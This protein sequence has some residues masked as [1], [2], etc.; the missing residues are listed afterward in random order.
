MVEKAVSYVDELSGEEKLALIDILRE[1][2]E[3]KVS[4]RLCIYQY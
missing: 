1:V 4:I 2:S 3:G